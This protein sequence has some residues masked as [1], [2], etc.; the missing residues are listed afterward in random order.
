[1]YYEKT[2]EEK[3]LELEQSQNI[4]LSLQ[5]KKLHQKEVERLKANPPRYSWLYR[6]FPGSKHW[7]WVGQREAERIG[8]VESLF[9]AEEKTVSGEI[10]KRLRAA[11]RA[12]PQYANGAKTI[13]EELA[14][15]ADAEA[16]IKA[17]FDKF[18]AAYVAKQADK[19]PEYSWYQRFTRNVPH[20]EEMRL[21]E[22]GRVA[23]KEIERMKREAAKAYREA[24]DRRRHE[25][26]IERLKKHRLQPKVRGHRQSA[27]AIYGAYQGIKNGTGAAEYAAFVASKEAEQAVGDRGRQAR[28]DKAMAHIRERDAG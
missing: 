6:H 13:D 19:V 18:V 26:N 22:C 28:I 2:D 17:V 15:L 27:E 3:L 4:R 7:D 1:M 8:R 11:R 24:G 23:R 12:N 10:A 5:R 14:D 20:L 16:E 9:L 25:A 21:L